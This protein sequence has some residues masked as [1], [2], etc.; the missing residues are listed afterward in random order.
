MAFRCPTAD[1]T[2][3]EK[4]KKKKK[5]MTSASHTGA[6]VGYEI[7]SS[8]LLSRG[9]DCTTSRDLELEDRGDRLVS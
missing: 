6:K 1:F 4:K 8:L 5:E 3:G 9:Q 2:N 7:T